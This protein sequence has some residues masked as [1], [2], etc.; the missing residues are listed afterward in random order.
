MLATAADSLG[1]VI[2]TSAT[3][4][5]ILICYVANVN[6]DAIAGLIV[7]LLV[8][9]WI[10]NCKRHTGAADRTEGSAELY[11]KISQMV[12]SYDGIVGT[13]DLIVHNYTKSGNGNHS[14]RGAERCEY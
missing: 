4:V 13:H 1:D 6:I 11:Q 10:F 8:I 9:W 12:E 2:T 5:S 3:V 14:C 7:S